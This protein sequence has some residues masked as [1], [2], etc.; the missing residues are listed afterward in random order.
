MLTTTG[1]AGLAL[2][3]TGT[4]ATVPRAPHSIHSLGAGDPAT[5]LGALLELALLAGSAW[6]LTAVALTAV[7]GALGRFGRALVPAAIRT[8]V[9]VGIAGAGLTGVA[10]ADSADWPVD[11]LRLPER[12][13]VDP[14]P[15]PPTPSSGAE[16][17]DPAGPAPAGSTARPPSSESPP[18][19]PAPR[20]ARAHEPTGPGRAAPPRA[21]D[22]DEDVRRQGADPGTGPATAGTSPDPG[23]SPVVVAPGDTLWALAAT[24]LPAG[25]TPREIQRLVESI[26]RLNR[27]VIGSDPDLIRPGQRID[28][29]TTEGTRR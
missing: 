17:Q 4:V 2:A 18:G 23:S 22:T 12:T 19:D 6:F 9:F 25:A 26:H 15:A 11:G 27:A 5:V 7:P 28:V 10:H 13:L 21:D 29:P 14:S 3:L 20:T 8:T 16:A 24:S 1:R